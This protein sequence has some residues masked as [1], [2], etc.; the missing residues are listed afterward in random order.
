M[1]GFVDLHLRHD[2][3]RADIA[4]RQPVE[5][6]VEVGLDLPLG[7]GHEAETGSVASTAGE[8]ADGESTGIPHRVEQRR[9][10]AE[11]GDALARPGEVVAFFAGRLAQASPQGL[12]GGDRCLPVVQSLGAH[13]TDVID[14]H[15]GGGQPAFVGAEI[16]VGQAKRGARAGSG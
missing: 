6:T 3:S 16:L 9:A 11:F 1:G 8:H 10:P 7:L 15:E 14:S 4:G 12:V 2:R 5:M 13:L